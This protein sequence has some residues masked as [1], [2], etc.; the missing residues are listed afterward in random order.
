[1]F[2]FT[3]MPTQERD[4]QRGPFK[5]VPRRDVLS[6]V[7]IHL[8]HRSTREQSA[9]DDAVTLLSDACSVFSISDLL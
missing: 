8:H 3:R 9:G 5:E 7:V 4:K 1:M 2:D 6:S